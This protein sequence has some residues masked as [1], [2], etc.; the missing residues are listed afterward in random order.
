MMRDCDDSEDSP[1]SDFVDGR[2]IKREGCIARKK[3]GFHSGMGVVFQKLAEISPI[4]GKGD[5]DNNEDGDDDEGK[6]KE[7]DDEGDDDDDDSGDDD[8]DNDESSWA[9]AQKF[10][11]ACPG[12]SDRYED[13][14]CTHDPTH[15]VCAQL[16]DSDWEPLKWGK[17]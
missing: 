14:S 15:R 6:K 5:G 9:A 8:D 2:S 13:F 10:V 12:E 17:A 16:L 1:H 7:K 4:G 11:S 3:E